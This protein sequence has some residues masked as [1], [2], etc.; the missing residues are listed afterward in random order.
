MKQATNGGTRSYKLVLLFL[1]TSFAAAV[2]YFS[3]GDHQPAAHAL[4]NGTLQD[5]WIDMRIGPPLISLFNEG[6]RSSDIARVDHPSQASQ[7][8]QIENGR[9]LAIFKSIAEAEEFLPQMADDID[10]IGYNL[11]H[12]QTTPDPKF[13]DRRCRGAGA[14]QPHPSN[15]LSFRNETLN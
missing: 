5:L 2:L 1:L 7:L 11:E 13:Q 9:K 14:G 3:S 4:Q 8:N 6:A 10:I 15:L 12:G